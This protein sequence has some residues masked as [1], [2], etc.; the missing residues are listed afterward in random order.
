VG[1]HSGMSTS[2]K[3]SLFLVRISLG[4]LFFYMGVTRVFFS[5]IP[6]S[7]ENY[8]KGAKTFVGFYNYLLQPNI[9]PA[10]NLVNEWGQ[11]LLGVSLILGVF[12]RP[13]AFL[14]AVLMLL[15]YFPGLDFP[16]AGRSSYIVDQHIIYGSTLL[17]LSITGAGRYGGLYSLFVK[18]PLFSKFPKLK[19]FL[20]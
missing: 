3:I 17:Y 16:H 1:Y 14:G 9:L 13:S 4:W 5:D 12:V 19:Y 6:W 15:Y 2:Q 20:S 18:I 10:I 8:L 7:A 11:L